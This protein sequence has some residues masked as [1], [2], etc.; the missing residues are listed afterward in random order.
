MSAWL[1]L[2]TFIRSELKV[3]ADPV[4][5]VGRS[6]NINIVFADDHRIICFFLF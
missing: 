4:G 6:I 1:S 5:N 2:D 3:Y